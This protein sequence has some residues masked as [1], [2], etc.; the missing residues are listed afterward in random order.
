MSED[1]LTFEEFLEQRLRLYTARLNDLARRVSARR[2]DHNRPVLQDM[3]CEARIGSIFG[4]H[5]GRRC[6]SLHERDRDLA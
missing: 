1:S 6:P 4:G 5:A 3:E 2:R